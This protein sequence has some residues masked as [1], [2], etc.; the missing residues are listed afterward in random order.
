MLSRVRKSIFLYCCR[1]SLSLSLV[2]TNIMYPTNSKAREIESTGEKAGESFSHFPS[3]FLLSF[4]LEFNASLGCVLNASSS[5]SSRNSPVT[6]VIC[7]ISGE[8]NGIIGSENAVRSLDCSISQFLF[9][10][11]LNVSC[12]TVFNL[13]TEC[14]RSGTFWMMMLCFFFHPTSRNDKHLREH[15]GKGPG[16]GARQGRKK[17]E[18][19]KQS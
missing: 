14:V 2:C 7:N 17:R 3:S 9:V 18:R 1:S 13:I 10:P 16:R 4:F 6:K 5:N 19:A 11:K 15:T 12:L 8:T